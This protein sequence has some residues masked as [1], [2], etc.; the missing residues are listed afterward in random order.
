MKERKESRIRG[1]LK[2]FVCLETENSTR[3]QKKDNMIKKL[4]GIQRAFL[5]LRKPK[6]K[7]TKYLTPEAKTRVKE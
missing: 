6:C 2:Y 7:C 3:S 5:K 4:S 1:Q